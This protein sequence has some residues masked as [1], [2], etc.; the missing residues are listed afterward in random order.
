MRSDEL[1]AIFPASE[2]EE[3]NRAQQLKSAEL[4][5]NYGYTSFHFNPFSY[6]TKDRFTG[7]G[8]L[9]L[10]FFDRKVVEISADYSNAPRIDRPE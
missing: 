5:P 8:N 4:A 7:I 9:R 2:Q 3:F 6:A 1:F 10:G